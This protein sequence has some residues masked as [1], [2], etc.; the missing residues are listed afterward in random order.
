MRESYKDANFNAKIINAWEYNDVQIILYTLRV[1]D[2]KFYIVAKRVNGNEYP[3][4]ISTD[5]CTALK[6]AGRWD[7]V[8]E[9]IAN[10]ECQ[11]LSPG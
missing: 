8:T 6:K 11:G 7:K 5:P 1:L 2:S 10:S 9:Q 4:S 3:L